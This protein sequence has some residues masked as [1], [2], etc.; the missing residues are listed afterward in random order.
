MPLGRE[1]ETPSLYRPKRF[2]ASRGMRGRRCACHPEFHGV[3]PRSAPVDH[4]SRPSFRS[5][6]LGGSQSSLLA[7]G[8]SAFDSVALHRFI[9]STCMGSW[10]KP[11]PYV[12][13][14]FHFFIFFCR[15]SFFLPYL[16]GGSLAWLPGPSSEA[17]QFAGCELRTSTKAMNEVPLEP[18][19]EPC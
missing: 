3:D 1:P 6:W 19:I 10:H 2:S 12:F 11:G 4:F 17:N 8:G 18:P 16:K 13:H 5:S 15:F 14:V 9:Y 7:C